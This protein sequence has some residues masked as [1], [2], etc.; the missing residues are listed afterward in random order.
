VSAVDVAV[1]LARGLGTRMRRDEG[2]ALTSA[3]RAAASSGAKALM[4][5]GR[6]A[7]IDHIVSALADA[8]LSRAVLV[9]PPD[10]GAFVSHFAARRS[11]RVRV[12]Y[13]VQQEA[14]GTA[15]AVL[16]ARSAIGSAP[17]VMV[18]GD[19]YYP[20]DAV[21]A[22]AS[23]GGHAM[24]GFD[25]A[26]LVDGGNIP[27]E[28]IAKYA[29]VWAD[30]QGHAV[31]FEEKPE[32]APLDDPTVVVSMNL[33]AFGPSIFTACARTRPS[34]RGE[35]ELADAVRVLVTE[36]GEPVRVVPVRGPVLDLSSRADIATV[37]R[38][39]ADR[40]AAP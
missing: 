35:L 19:N 33:W 4:P 30:A 8:G 28:R 32:P 13:A 26:S 2:A 31:R 11:P 5:V 24:G 17:F 34:V 23:A 18:N 9:V 7:L 21:R 37:E 38:L 36:L 15:N 22:V 16:S 12:E 27:R 6:H 1:V 40:E 14:L 29:F 25:P 3:Q 10:H 39:L 20:P